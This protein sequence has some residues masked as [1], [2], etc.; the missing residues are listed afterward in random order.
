MG[1]GRGV[2]MRLQEEQI[3]VTEQGE[4]CRHRAT[5]GADSGHRTRGE[6]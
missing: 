4:R 5:G 1:K 3:Q 2:D 6:M